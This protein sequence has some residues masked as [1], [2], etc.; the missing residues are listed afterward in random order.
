[1]QADSGSRTLYVGGLEESVTPDLLR[2]AFIVFGEI[3]TVELP[4]DPKTGKH[5]GFGFVEFEETDDAE[6]AIDNMHESEILGRVLTV[7]LA[8]GSA[9]SFRSKRPVWADDFFYRQGLAEQGLEVDEN[10]LAEG[11]ATENKQKKASGAAT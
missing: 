1:M 9:K 8:R 7:N 3:R 10:L 5:R 2:S 4:I 11:A 6:H